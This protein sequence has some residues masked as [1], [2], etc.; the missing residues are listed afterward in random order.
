MA[1]CP[2]CEHKL[3][4]TDWKQKCPYCG[5]NV[6]LYNLQER[7]MLDAD[8][9]EVQHFYFQ[10]KVDRAKASY[11]GSKPAIARIVFSLLPPLAVLLPMFS[12]RFSVPFGGIA[13][14]ELLKLDAIRLYQLIGEADTGALL[15]AAL[16][17]GANGAVF[18]AAI[19]CLALSLVLTLLHFILLFLSCSP[20]GKSRNYTLHILQLVFASAFVILLFALPAGSFVSAAAPGL[21]AWIYLALL[22]V[23]FAVEILVYRKGIEI[24]HKQCYVGGIP[25]EEYF[26]MLEKNV[27]HEEIR[28]EMYR[29]LTLQQQERE[30]KLAE[31]QEKKEKAKEAAGA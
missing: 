13:A 14:G 5:A 19:V 27:P 4:L 6:F 22:I 11:A 21:G 31:E 3:R 26:Q 17:A 25:I 24:N 7:L 16:D 28:A 15:K 20:H 12:A 8:K 30:R 29:R 9:A 18:L 2:K 23:S 10:K 1:N